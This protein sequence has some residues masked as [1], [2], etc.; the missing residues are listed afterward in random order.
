VLLEVHV[1]YKHSLS[2]PPSLPNVTFQ[3]VISS[4][5]FR[6]SITTLLL[7][8]DCKI[9]APEHVTSHLSSSSSSAAAA[10]QQQH[11]RPVPRSP[12]PTR[13]PNATMEGLLARP[14]TGTIYGLACTCW[15]GTSDW[16]FTSLGGCFCHRWWHISVSLERDFGMVF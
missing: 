7:H 1:Q 6:H 13:T 3:L 4:T 16:A 12:I 11:R 8:P 5:V 15:N 9:H 2:L 14:S 10:C